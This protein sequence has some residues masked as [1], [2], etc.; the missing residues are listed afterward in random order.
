[1]TVKKM[2]AY[3][4]TKDLDPG[5]AIENITQMIVTKAITASNH[6]A[7]AEKKERK[8]ENVMN[9]SRGYSNKI[10]LLYS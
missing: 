6:Q 3:E 9:N 8:W 2:A 7:K 10:I 1:M 5:H 4:E